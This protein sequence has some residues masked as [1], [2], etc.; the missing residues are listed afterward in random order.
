[1]G[2]TSKILFAY[3]ECLTIASLNVVG[4]IVSYVTGPKHRQTAAGEH[5]RCLYWVATPPLPIHVF[6]RTA[7]VVKAAL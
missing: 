7:S 3:I 4:T 6:S 1:M 2:S 5:R